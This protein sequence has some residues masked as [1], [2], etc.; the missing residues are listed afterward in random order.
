MSRDKVHILQI[1]K[2]PAPR[3]QNLASRLPTDLLFLAALGVAFWLAHMSDK[4]PLVDKP[5]SIQRADAPR[6][7]DQNAL[8][9]RV[10]DTGLRGFE[11]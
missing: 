2:R 11:R 10:M 1:K 5:I 3:G 8:G 9:V 6:V 4:P 7:A